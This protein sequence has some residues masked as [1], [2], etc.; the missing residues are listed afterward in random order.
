[1]AKGKILIIDADEAKAEQ[2]WGIERRIAKSCDKTIERLAQSDL[3]VNEAVCFTLIARHY[4]RIVA[5][6]VKIAT[7]VILPLSDLDYFDEERTQD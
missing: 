5:H 2:A 3:S 7:S 6:L 4:K 1:M